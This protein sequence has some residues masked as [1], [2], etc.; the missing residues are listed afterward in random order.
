VEVGG[1]AGVDVESAAAAALELLLDR[2]V[3]GVDIRGGRRT[4]GAPG[5]RRIRD[6]PGGT[7]PGE[8][9]LHE[10]AERRGH[11]HEESPPVH[12]HRCA[13][14]FTAYP[15]CVRRTAGEPP[16][17]HNTM[18]PPATSTYP[19]NHTHQTSGLIVKRYTAC[20]VPFTRPPRTT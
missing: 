13:S 1:A 6:L 19:P 2:L 16:P 11:T 20:S 10:R 14:S 15:A 18:R 5:A 7:G 12:A 17:G 8:A 3:R 4:E 9:V